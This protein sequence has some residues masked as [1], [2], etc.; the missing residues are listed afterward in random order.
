MLDERCAALVHR[1]VHHLCSRIP[2]YRLPEVLLDQPKLA[3]VGR[4]TLRES[5]RYVRM[6]LWD[7]RRRRLISSRDAY[8]RVVMNRTALWQTAC[9]SNEHASDGHREGLSCGS[10]LGRQVAVDLEADADLDKD[11]GYPRHGT[12]HEIL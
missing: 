11:R 5:L 9:R 7:E 6:I 3:A 4:L 8:S 2:N 1:H 10:E 12:L